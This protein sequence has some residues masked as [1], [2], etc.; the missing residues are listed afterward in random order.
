MNERSKVNQTE[1]NLYSSIF[2]SPFHRTIMTMSS[3]RE[4]EKRGE[5]K[6]E[7]RRGRERGEREGYS[8]T[9]GTNS[10][11]RS[12]VPEKSPECIN[13]ITKEDKLWFYKEPFIFHGWTGRERGR[14]WNR[15]REREH[16][17]RKG[18]RTKVE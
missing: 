15:E 18:K 3:R 10:A 2:R 16:M 7:K 9:K 5:G 4:R 11:S 8:T 1:L 6:K 14:K 12:S 13:S 17:D